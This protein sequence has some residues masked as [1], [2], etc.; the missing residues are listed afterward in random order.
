MVTPEKA[1]SE[2]RITVFVLKK[3]PLLG[4]ALAIALESV[5]EALEKRVPAGTFAGA[6]VC[7]FKLVISFVQDDKRKKL[8]DIYIN[9]FILIN[10]LD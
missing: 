7:S 9:F 1:P 6:L 5:R 3:R 10:S 8:N 2:R 4:Q